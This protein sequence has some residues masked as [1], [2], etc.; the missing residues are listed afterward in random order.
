MSNHQSICSDAL[1]NCLFKINYFKNNFLIPRLS[2]SLMHS[3]PCYYYIKITKGFYRVYFLKLIYIFLL[4]L[5]HNTHTYKDNINFIFTFWEIWIEKSSR[6]SLIL[7]GL[8]LA[9][10]ERYWYLYLF[11]ASVQ[12]IKSNLIGST[13]H[14]V[15]NFDSVCWFWYFLLFRQ[16]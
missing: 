8:E 12:F 9:L 6:I 14:N 16:C 7:L 4:A 15:L 1:I 13:I 10:K 3:H 11:N 5:F 2:L